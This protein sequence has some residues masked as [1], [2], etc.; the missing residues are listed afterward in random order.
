M[1]MMMQQIAYIFPT[2]FLSVLFC[3]VMVK[4]FDFSHL[5]VY[6]G[7]AMSVAWLVFLMFLACFVM[8]KRKFV[9]KG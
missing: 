5:T 6:L 8:K 3:D 7:S 1:P 2:N 9:K 4:G